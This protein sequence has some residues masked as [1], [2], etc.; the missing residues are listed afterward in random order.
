MFTQANTVTILNHL[1]LPCGWINQTTN[2]TTTLCKLQVDQSP[3]HPPSITRSLTLL[4][5]YTWK[6]HIHGRP[7]DTSKCMAL[8]ELP[9]LVTSSAVL[10]R[11]LLRLDRLTVCV[12]NPDT[13]F[14]KLA[15]SRKGVF[16][17]SNN[18][19]AAVLDGVFPVHLDGITYPET[20]RC[21]SCE[22]LVDGYRCTSCKQYR[23]TL[24]SL[25]SRWTSQQVS[26]SSDNNAAISSHTN[27]R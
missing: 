4:S 20:V 16:I 26:N 24:R 23:P 11:I 18:Q 21:S 17:N 9:Q 5:D 25:H 15:A 27:Y 3:D 12:G 1:S 22:L 13:H 2:G 19:P 8:G 6:V 10:S 7:V 14:I